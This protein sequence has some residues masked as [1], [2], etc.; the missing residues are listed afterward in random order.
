MTDFKKRALRFFLLMAIMLAIVFIVPYT[1]SL[2]KGGF[3]EPGVFDQFQFYQI[4]AIVAFVILTIVFIVQSLI[5]K[6]DDRY[7]NSTGFASPGETPSLSFFQRFTLPQLTLFSIIVFLL[8]FM[9]LFTSGTAQKSF[10][11]VSLL[12]KQQFSTTDSLIYST[13]LIP[14]AENA[15]AGAVIAL[16]W[17]GLGL[18]ARK[19]NW[20]SGL[21]TGLILV[22]TPLM[23]GVFGVAWH[24]TVYAGSDVALQTVFFF[25]MIGG[26]LVT[27]SGSFIIFWLMHLSNN[28]FIDL[29]RSFSNEGILGIVFIIIVILALIYFRV[30]R[31]RLLG[32]K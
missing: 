17:L 16:L 1:I 5:V 31:G 11:G 18:L 6:G 22:I 4:S 7:G 24:S 12:Q 27:L 2:S 9:L 28:L 20:S 14:I 3:D 21:F 10:T 13:A 8:L 26:L 25:W 30:Y 19:Y 15:V 29:S 23:L 32:E